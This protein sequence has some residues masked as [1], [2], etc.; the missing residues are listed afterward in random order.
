MTKRHVY[1][2]V[3]LVALGTVSAATW[4]AYNTVLPSS[5]P[6]VHVAERERPDPDAPAE[7]KV[8]RNGPGL[9]QSIGDLVA[10]A[11]A[12]LTVRLSSSRTDRVDLQLKP[13]PFCTPFTTLRFWNRSRAA[14]LPVPPSESLE[15]E[16]AGPTK[17]T[18][19]GPALGSS[20]WCS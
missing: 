4:R 1:F 13:I 5:F 8:D 15:V 19:L 17:L 6:P 2:I 3:G 7:E 20:S 11:D 18:F 9:D 12:V 14:S 16:G 10:E